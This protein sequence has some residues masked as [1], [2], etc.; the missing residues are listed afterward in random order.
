MLKVEWYKGTSNLSEIYQ[1]TKI[2]FA[3]LSTPKEGNKQCHPFVLCRDF[4]HDAVRC[5]I[6]KNKCQIY[7]FCYEYG[8]N[9]PI[10]TKYMR[11]LVTRQELE[12]TFS[13]KMKQSLK[14]INHYESIAGWKKSKL[15]RVDDKTKPNTWLFLG[16]KE[17]LKSPFLVS[18]YT[19]L[20]RLGDKHGAI[21]NFK[22]TEELIKCF[23]TIG[24]SQEAYGDNDVVYIRECF[25]KMH[26][27]VKEA[28]SLFLKDGSVKE[29]PIYSDTKV[30]LNSFHNNCGIYNL[31]RGQAPVKDL[32]EKIKL[33][34]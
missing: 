1:S 20:I 16:P 19:F 30:S 28:N 8:K 26:H 2:K 21:S 4:L 12:E 29:D 13:E 7:G 17:W 9:P 34:K 23:S 24:K 27:I 33:L 18:M 3:F 10:D 25:N 32:N 11:M 6:Q 15:I 22:T 14:I 5:M 31:C